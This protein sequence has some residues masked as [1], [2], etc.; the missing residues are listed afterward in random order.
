MALAT[1][2]PHSL[3]TPVITSQTAYRHCGEEGRIP[4]RTES[5]HERLENSVNTPVDP[6]GDCNQNVEQSSKVSQDFEAGDR[7]QCNIVDRCQ[8][9]V[10]SKGEIQ[11]NMNVGKDGDLY[12]MGTATS[13]NIM[14]Q[15]TLVSGDQRIHPACIEQNLH[16]SEKGT[17]T[18][19]FNGELALNLSGDQAVDV[20]CVGDAGD[21][22]EDVIG[23]QA[24]ARTLLERL[25][26]M[27]TS[28]PSHQVSA[29]A[30]LSARTAWMVGQSANEQVCPLL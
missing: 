22:M 7:K 12:E 13:T 15:V 29:E 25:L 2:Q 28:E 30:F 5:R 16:A 6:C 18:S 4:Q 17:C 1:T 11:C 14:E 9:F 20:P 10:D 27:W 23:D 8:S 26:A 3:Y 24:R 21:C 19:P